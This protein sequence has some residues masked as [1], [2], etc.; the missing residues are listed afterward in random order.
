MHKKNQ[1]APPSDPWKL[2]QG[3]T[4]YRCGKQEQKQRTFRLLPGSQQVIVCQECY[5]VLRG[6]QAYVGVD[7]GISESGYRCPACD[8]L[9]HLEGQ[10]EANQ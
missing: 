1:E 3:V 10:E 4:C 7:K 2:P 6:L 8:E 5:Q 9:A